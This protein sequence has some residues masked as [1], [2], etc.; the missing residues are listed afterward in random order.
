MQ[1]NIINKPTLNRHSNRHFY[2]SEK[3][4]PQELLSPQII[5]IFIEDSPVDKF[6]SENFTFR[7]SQYSH[8]IGVQWG[9]KSHSH[10]SKALILSLFRQKYGFCRGTRKVLLSLFYFSLFCP[11]MPCFARDSG[12]MVKCSEIT[13]Y[14][15]SEQTPASCYYLLVVKLVVKGK[16]LLLKVLPFLLHLFKYFIPFFLVTPLII[17]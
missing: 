17:F 2:A 16:W 8:K 15:K 14:G 9:Y 7:L 3:K 12:V 4:S 10:S 6:Q 11:G 5:F 13:D 1:S